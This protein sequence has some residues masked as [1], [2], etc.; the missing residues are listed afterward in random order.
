M[1]A[2]LS[3]HYNTG[4][5]DLFF[6]QCFEIVCKLGVG[7]FGE[8]FKVRSKEDGRYYAVKRSRERFRGESD[9]RRKLE[10]V[11]K[12]EELPTHPNCVGFVKAWEEKQHL[13]IQTEL[14]RTSLYDFA[15][16]N[17]NIPEQL[18]WNYLV[19]LL[20]AVKHLHDHDLVHMDIKPE[21][22]FISDDG[23]CKLGDFGLVL[24]LRK[25]NC[26]YRQ[27]KEQRQ[28]SGA[29]KPEASGRWG[30]L[31]LTGRPSRRRHKGWLRL[32][33]AAHIGECSN[34]TEGQIEV[35]DRNTHIFRTFEDSGT[36]Y[37]SVT[38]GMMA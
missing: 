24:D 5:K 7:S 15:E 6:D 11:A 22:I 3:P 35:L 13:Y 16:L 8:V 17:H 27:E 36:Q 34:E 14:C 19:D 33:V 26:F 29:L 20:M 2:L 28:I 18:I 1:P 21:N 9:R 31:T 12:H 30:S 32:A 4:I 38:D 23:I 25:R 10:E 37:N